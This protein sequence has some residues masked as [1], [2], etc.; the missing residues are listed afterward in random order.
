MRHTIFF[1]LLL[2]LSLIATT[3]TLAQNLAEPN[4][5]WGHPTQQEL[6]MTEY[7]PDPDADAVV[8][9][10]TTNVHYIITKDVLQVLYEVK[11]RIKILKPE[12]IKHANVD[13]YYT[14]NDG[15]EGNREEVSQ[16]K[17][18]TFNIVN[19]QIGRA[20]V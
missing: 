18:T 15:A 4:L 10:K 14:V 19:G 7:T 11:G 16:V 6:E 1:T 12:G 2:S 3:N 5:K 17:G 8:L 20:H 13:I 9:C